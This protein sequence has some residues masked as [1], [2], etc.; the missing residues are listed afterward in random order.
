MT[1]EAAREKL[2]EIIDHASEQE[3]MTLLSLAEGIKD[4]NYKYDDATLSM[5][6]ERS[7]AYLSG[8]A[9]TFSIE[10]SLE[11]IKVHRKKNGL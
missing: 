11:R 5:L 3:I 1:I 10:E 2:H 9:Q 6:K 7:E 4:V 8:K